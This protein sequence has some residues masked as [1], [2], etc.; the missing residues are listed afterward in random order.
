[1]ETEI[2][3]DVI[4]TILLT[5]MTMQIQVVNT[6]THTHDERAGQVLAGISVCNTSWRYN[7]VQHHIFV[8]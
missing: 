6:H 5:R 2:A 8:Y 3:H 4:N 1:M 7:N